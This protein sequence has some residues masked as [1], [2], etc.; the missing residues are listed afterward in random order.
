MFATPVSNLRRSLLVGLGRCR[1]L[2]CR[3]LRHVKRAVSGRGAGRET[4]SRADKAKALFCW[5][6]GKARAGAL[7]A[8]PVPAPPTEPLA[9]TSRATHSGTSG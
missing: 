4:D 5:V 3:E 8:L 2:R 7:A 6:E 1:D 9:V